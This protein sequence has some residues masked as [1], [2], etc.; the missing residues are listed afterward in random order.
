[1][2]VLSVNTIVITERPNLEKLLSCFNPGILLTL[3]SIGIVINLSMSGA[4]RAGET[5]II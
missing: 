4:P 5:V 2:S 3:C 1:M